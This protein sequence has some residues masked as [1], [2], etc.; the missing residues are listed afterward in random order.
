MSRKDLSCEKSDMFGSF[1]CRGVTGGLD[2]RLILPESSITSILLSSDDAPAF[3]T[4]STFELELLDYDATSSLTY[5]SSIEA[6][7]L[8]FF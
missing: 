5:S 4:A 6:L 8:T 1:T 7:S 3:T 2:L